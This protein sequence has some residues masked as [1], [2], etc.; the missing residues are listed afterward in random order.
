METLINIPWAIFLILLPLAGA[1]TCFLWPEKTKIVGLST[2]VSVVI[3][4]AGLTWVMVKNG[5]FHHT[6]GGW[7]APLGIDLYADGL[8]LL[9]LIITSLVG[10]GISIYATGYFNSNYSIRFWPLWLFIMAALNA[11]FL[12]ADIFNFYITLELMGLAAVALTAL[13]TSTDSLTG[14]M[15]YLL[16]TLLGSLVYL[17]GVALL[18]HNFGSVDIMILS[19]RI[20]ST[21]IVWAALGLMSTGLL[22]KTALFPLHFWLPSAH[23]SAPAPVSAILSALIIKASFYILLRI[24]LDIFAPLG[25]ELVAT[26]FGVFGSVA[27]LWGSIQA[28]LQTRLKLLI[29]YSTIA[30]IGYLFLAFSLAI[31]GAMTA[32]SAVIYLMFSHALAKSAMFL[33]AGN[34]MHFC[35]HDRIKDLDRIAQRL[36]VTA[37]AFALA[38]VSIVGLPPS[39]GFIGKWFLL[40]TALQQEQW[41]FTAVIMLGSLLAAGYIFKVLGFAFT[42]AVTPYDPHAIPAHMEWAALL[43]A[44]MS[45]I[46]GF[47]SS[48]LLFIVDIGNPF[49]IS[50]LKR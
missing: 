2:I 12:S 23:A 10:L 38:G 28:L 50:E 21:P 8:S 4:V 20:E 6:V 47:F 48:P 9:M 32:W 40:E 29:A 16:A 45:I 17:F 24:W 43:L 37:A 33:V 42:Q 1:I 13:G 36:P 49:E 44:C 26:L 35:G 39:G 5:P 7:G 15:R 22:L 3:S 31:S 19:Q 41:A 18:Y 46:V 30:Q 11:L 34:L 27:I 14:A 25:Y